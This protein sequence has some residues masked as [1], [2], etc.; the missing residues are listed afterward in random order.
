MSTCQDLESGHQALCTPV[1]DYLAKETLTNMSKA[2][3]PVILTD[4]SLCNDMR[5]CPCLR[6]LF[7]WKLKRQKHIF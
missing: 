7:K 1:R 5:V 2:E 3:F 6:H 4:V